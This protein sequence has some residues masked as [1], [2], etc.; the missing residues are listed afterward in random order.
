ML[1]QIL[2]E[3]FVP[4]IIIEEDSEIADLEREKVS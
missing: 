4:E 2:S 3:D 1:R